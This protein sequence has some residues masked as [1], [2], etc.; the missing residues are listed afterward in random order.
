MLWLLRTLLMALGVLAGAALAQQPAATANALPPEVVQALAAAR[1]PT[2]A[3]AMMVVPL[4]EAEQTT[5]PAPLLAWRAEE[6]MNPAS[7]MK[8]VTTYAG[9]DALGPSY[10]WR[11][12]IEACGRIEDGTLHGDLLVRGSGDPKLVIERLTDLIAAIQEKGVRR[13]TGDILLDRS[14]FDL[15]EHDAAAFDSDPLRPYNVG[16]DGLLMN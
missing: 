2:S 8:L 4:P 11:T 6:P 5:A 14:I 9:L 13:I 1:V 10:F 12:R 15:A 3:V 16:P 7:V